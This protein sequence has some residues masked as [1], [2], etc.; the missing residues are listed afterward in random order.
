ME[1]MGMG[2]RWIY[3]KEE[4]LCWQLHVAQEDQWNTEE[5]LFFMMVRGPTLNNPNR[6]RTICLDNGTEYPNGTFEGAMGLVQLHNLLGRR[7]NCHMMEIRMTQVRVWK[8]R[9]IRRVMDVTQQT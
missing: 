6:K 9:E 2:R 5:I 7:D 4:A 3:L 1:E 8:S